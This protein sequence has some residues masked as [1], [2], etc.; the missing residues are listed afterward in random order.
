MNYVT[1]L[2]GAAGICFG[3][4][5]LIMRRVSPEKFAKLEA[6]KKMWGEAAGSVVHL[7]GYSVLPIVFGILMII[8]GVNGGGFF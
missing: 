7:I 3:I 6:M 2:I 5:V 1:I 8:K 4:Y